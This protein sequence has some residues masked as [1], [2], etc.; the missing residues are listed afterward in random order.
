MSGRHES[1]TSFHRLGGGG[2][3]SSVS[4]KT[5]G[6]WS[7]PGGQ[8]GKNP[9]GEDNEVLH[10]SSERF[11]MKL[12]RDFRLLENLT[13]MEAGLEAPK[14][15]AQ[16]IE[17]EK[18][19]L[20]LLSDNP[21]ALVKFHN[22]APRV[23][24]PKYK[25]L[26]E[27]QRKRLHKIKYRFAKYHPPYDYIANNIVESKWFKYTIEFIIYFNL[28]T[29]L[30]QTSILTEFR[31]ASDERIPANLNTMLLY[32]YPSSEVSKYPMSYLI[33]DTNNK[34]Y[35]SSF[36]IDN[37]VSVESLDDCTFKIGNEVL[38]RTELEQKNF[39]KTSCIPSSDTA[40]WSGSEVTNMCEP[41]FDQYWKELWHDYLDKIFFSFE[42][43]IMVIFSLEVVLYWIDG[44]KRY[45]SSGTKIFD[46]FITVMCFIPIICKE[47]LKS[48]LANYPAYSQEIEKIK[49]CPYLV[50]DGN[51]VDASNAVG[52][53]AWKQLLFTVYHS[54]KQIVNG[55]STSF[56]GTE[57]D[58]FCNFASQHH[59]LQDHYAYG[60]FCN[61]SATQSGTILVYIGLP[62]IQALRVLRFLKLT[63]SRRKVQD[64]A[65]AIVKAMK[66]LTIIMI[67]FVVFIVLFG[68]MI[69]TLFSENGS[70]F[71]IEYTEE[72]FK[73]WMQDGTI[74]QRGGF[75]GFISMMWTFSILFQMM[76]LDRW[77]SIIGQVY[78]DA[79][80]PES[81]C[82]LYP[83]SIQSGWIMAGNWS[84]LMNYLLIFVLLFGWFWMGCLIF[85][86]LITSIIV[87][88][89][90]QYSN[91]I[92]WG[93]NEANVE[94][95][96]KNIAEEIEEEVKRVELIPNAVN[97]VSSAST[98]DSYASD[99][100][101]DNEPLIDQLEKHSEFWRENWYKPWRYPSV[102][103]IFPNLSNKID[104]FS[105][106]VGKIRDAEEHA[107]TVEWGNDELTKEETRETF[108]KRFTGLESDNLKP[109]NE[110]DNLKRLSTHVMDSNNLNVNTP[111]AA[112]LR[113]GSAISMSNEINMN[114]LAGKLHQIRKKS[115]A[116]IF[117]NGDSD[118]TS[119]DSESDVEDNARRLSGKSSIYSMMSR[120]SQR[121]SSKD[122]QEYDTADFDLTQWELAV[123][124]HMDKIKGYPKESLWPRDI[125]FRYYQLQERLQ[126]NIQE[127]KEILDLFMQC[128]VN[129]HDS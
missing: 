95:E 28:I 14:Y 81:S 83:P 110:D 43:F 39:N 68:L 79:F 102:Q 29:V 48:L 5:V 59:D 24:N 107:E 116:S 90:L 104:E 56:M 22:V 38:N 21:N 89:Y 117:S 32:K 65:A 98:V 85:K 40:S 72:Q 15:H 125:L 42:I 3:R 19:R 63:F 97:T 127:R 52:S 61:I 122:A 129:D 93:E 73:E 35:V 6:I 99:I 115:T 36:V 84:L 126:E 25:H 101:D 86:N 37:T 64:I 8:E 18:K 91:E 70:E 17:D 120:K 16:D 47:H 113:R 55:K 44:F 66:A 11:R 12:I 30:I 128:M 123:Q 50:F 78:Y 53:S 108:M 96:L 34:P 88:N 13:E 1:T 82:D 112:L 80:N 118:F 106:R 60:Y 74:H 92:R 2:V 4:R 46:F 41:F 87:N 49:D 58:Q 27:I 124:I 121:R 57:R 94:R 75:G 100:Y 54:Y 111:N 45:W 20:K 77:K 105:G 31:Q 51:L 9:N 10:S 69:Y 103:R 7:S 71:G 76:T 67:L 26:N 62:S 109:T 33:D 119:S 114:N 23:D